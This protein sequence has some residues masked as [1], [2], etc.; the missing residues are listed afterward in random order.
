[1][2]AHGGVSLDKLSTDAGPPGG[3]NHPGPHP[4]PPPSAAFVGSCPLF[5]RRP[6]YVVLVPV[7]PILNEL[8]LPVNVHRAVHRPRSQR[9]LEGQGARQMQILPMA[10]SA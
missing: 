10:S 7:W 4:I 8:S 5:G 2:S 6:N 9:D 1:M 3:A